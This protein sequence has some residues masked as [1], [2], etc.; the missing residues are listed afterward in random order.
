MVSGTLISLN[1]QISVFS[2]FQ[3]SIYLNFS[4]FKRVWIY[5]MLVVFTNFQTLIILYTFTLLHV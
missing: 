2:N 4:T 1:F 5:E 3:N